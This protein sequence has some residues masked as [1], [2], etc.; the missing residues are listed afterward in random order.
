MVSRPEVITSEIDG[1]THEPVEKF[2]RYSRR[3]RVVTKI[4]QE[5]ENDQNNGLVGL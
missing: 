1:K 5:K 3:V 2:Y 4:Y